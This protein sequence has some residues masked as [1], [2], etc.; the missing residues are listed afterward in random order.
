MT[1][2]TVTSAYYLLG[3]KGKANSSF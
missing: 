1:F 3:E 2:N